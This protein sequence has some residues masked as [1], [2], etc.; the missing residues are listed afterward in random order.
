MDSTDKLSFWVLASE[1]GDQS[2]AWKEIVTY[3]NTKGIDLT[4]AM[5]QICGDK[6]LLAMIWKEQ[7]QVLLNEPEFD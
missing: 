6:S 7:Y 5:Y 3:Y 2:E 4:S 1:G